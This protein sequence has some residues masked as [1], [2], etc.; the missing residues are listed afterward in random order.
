M[1][2]FVQTT[3]MKYFVNL[4]FPMK[5]LLTIVMLFNFAFAKAQN[6]W[7]SVSQTPT[8]NLE[9]R[10]FT[11]DNYLTYNLDIDGLK[12]FVTGSPMRFTTSH[13]NVVV[14]MP[15][16][17]GDF[18]DFEIFE[19]Q[20]MENSLSAKYPSIKT[21]LGL[22][23]NDAADVIR[24]SITSH[25]FHNIEF[26][27][28]APTVYIDPFTI[29]HNTYIVYDRSS[30]P[31]VKEDFECLMDELSVIGTD[32]NISNVV[33]KS[34]NDSSLRTYRV[35]ISCNAE[36]GNLFAGNGTDAQKRAN[37]QARQV[38]T[39]NRVNGVYERDLAINMIFV[40]NNDSLL[41]FGDTSLD[42][43]T[44]DFNNRTQD[45]IDGDLAS[46]GFPGIGNAN[47]DIG[48][49]F[50]TSGGGNAGCI[51][52][53]CV[54]GQKGSGMTGRANPT[55]DPFDIDYVAHE[56]GHQ[57]GGYHSM[58]SSNCRS[59][60]GQTEVEPGSGST[61]MAYAGICNPNIQN[62]SDDYFHYVNIRDITANIKSGPS[63]SCAVVTNIPFTAP[64]VDAGLDYTIPYSTAFV[65]TGSATNLGTETVV[66]NWEQN[67]PENPG[68]NNGPDP[69]RVQG[70]MYRSLPSVTVPERYF[71]ALSDVVQGNLAPS[72]EVTPSV[73]RNME[74][75]FTARKYN[76]NVGQN[77][78]DLMNITV[79]GIAGPFTVTSQN[80]NVS[81]NTGEAFVVNWDVAGTDQSPINTMSV[82]ILMSTDG[83]L[84]FND[85]IE[86]ATPNDGTQT[87]IMPVVSPT[88]QAR[89]MVKANSNVYYAI[90]SSNFT[91]TSDEFSLSTTELEQNVCL[92]AN[93][94]YDFTYRTFNGFNTPTTLSLTG[95]PV[96]S[97][98]VI[99]PSTVT[100]NN[101]PVNITISGLNSS[102]VGNYNL[103][104]DGTA[105]ST[106]RSVG[107]T[108]N[109]LESSLQNT[110]LI[111][112]VDMAIDVALFP[113]LEWNA[114]TGAQEYDVE[115]SSDSSF[116]IIVEATTTAA[117]T[118]TLT[119]GLDEDT[120]YYWR[121]RNKN[122][123]G[124][125]PFSASR[126]FRTANIV[127]FNE[128]STV[129]PITIS[130]GPPS[131]FDTIITVTDNVVINDIV[132]NIDLSH[133]WM[134]D[135]DIYLTSPSGTQI[136]I[137]ED[138]CN[139]RNDLLA[140]FTDDG[141]AL[142]CT[143]AAP[144]VSGTILAVDTFSSFNGGNALGDWVL[145][146]ADDTD[147][148]G[149]SLN[150]WSVD[151]CGTQTLS[152]IDN[153]FDD[154][155]LYPNPSKESVFLQLDN[156]AFAEAEYDIYDMA[157]RFITSQEIVAA[158]TQIDLSHWSSG[159]YLI[160]V[161]IDHQTIVKQIIKE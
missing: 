95:E 55:G 43:Y 126:S 29:D 31:E 125:G 74:F 67:D 57:F 115:V 144:T 36:Y 161:T 6:F 53:V 34:T 75:A 47:Y 147:Q 35:A 157:G 106:M 26:V 129:V 16:A 33:P 87:V 101:T 28:G 64:V 63:S 3:N 134:S 45:L 145:T 151:I 50:N 37:I 72:Y 86:V 135:V 94:S 70:P 117:S 7:Q 60:S 80:S 21:Y 118:Y 84:N 150:G 68:S 131:S 44:N 111:E 138:R 102:M 8:E 116:N 19:T 127:C 136:T 38:I 24:F 83:G 39:M 120:I 42:P 59:G 153:V 9:N 2:M 96:G 56:M 89:I 152:T 109:V 62:N 49:N 15:N 30:I 104:F 103:S 132:L 11:P 160:K 88:S 82:D 66:Y 142:Q 79:D 25:G 123:C 77:D 155:S 112:P 141:A 40:A 32:L 108:L 22:N 91:V 100:N 148:D 143:F 121:V 122:V 158:R 4:L 52:C 1:K 130:S 90:N 107:L 69:T 12:Q 149:G 13:S 10:N 85:I 17:D 97:T 71:P 76:N 58:A 54:T 114:S 20:I 140:T 98:V 110:T 99:T 65:L 137:I 48:H 105:G 18:Y 146:V 124:D 119:T 159:M 41:Y 93:A 78:S 92:P 81:Y 5:Y 23:V 133:T 73:A 27:P 128:S 156:I 51:G 46:Q 113:T 154:I 139:N 14:S 61:I